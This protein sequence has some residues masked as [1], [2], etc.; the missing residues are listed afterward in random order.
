MN[1]N[2]VTQA[3]GRLRALDTSGTGVLNLNSVPANQQARVTAIIQQLGGNPNGPINI[4]QLERRAMAANN[5]QQSNQP[6]DNTGR[7]QRRQTGEPLVRPFGEQAAANTPVLEFGQRDAASQTAQGGRGQQGR[8]QRDIA[9]TQ[10]QQ[11]AAQAARNANTVRQSATYDSIPQTVRNNPAFSW[12]FEYD[13]DKDGQLTML[14]YRNGRGGTWTD[15]LAEEFSRLDRN[16]DGF[17][18]VDEALTTIVEWDREREQQ[19]REQQVAG[20]PQQQGR[21][22]PG[23]QMAGRPTPTGTPA[24]QNVRSNNPNGQNQGNPRQQAA[25]NQG[26]NAQGRGNQQGG[27]GGGPGGGGNFGGNRGGR[28]GGG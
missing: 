9:T 8:Q 11:A 4:A 12:F 3:I 28:G 23:Q 15:E 16:G 7:Q 2:Q 5:A 14:E 26:G 1:A 21:Q 27:R 18:T 19:E 20:G 10:A 13:T 22:Q 25:G 6:A 17:V 24:N